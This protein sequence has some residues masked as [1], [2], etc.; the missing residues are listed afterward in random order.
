MIVSHKHKFVFIKTRKTAGSSIEAILYPILG[1]NDICSGSSRDGTPNLNYGKDLIGHMPFSQ[2]SVAYPKAMQKYFVFTVE[3]NPWDK[4][5]SAFY[6]HK[7]I[8][9]NLTKQGFNQYLR[10]AEPLLPTDWAYYGGTKTHV[11]KYEE[12]SQFIP[13]MN[14]KFKLDLDPALMYNTRKKSGIRETEH[15]RDM[16]DEDSKLFVENL[17]H[18]EVK[19]FGYEF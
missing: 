12:L 9:P 17:F 8:K 13:F 7:K 11:F 18:K 14:D 5:V 4:C 1:E 3:R 10:D 16:Y 2:L 15:Y 19:E 6:W